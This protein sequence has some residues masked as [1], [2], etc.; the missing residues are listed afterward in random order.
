MI[1]RFDNGAKLDVEVVG[2]P[3]AIRQGLMWRKSLVSDGGMLFLFDARHPH[4]VWMKNTLITLDAAFLDTDGN[5]ALIV[6]GLVAGLVPLS[7]DIHQGPV[8][9][10]MLEV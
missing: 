8:S 6:A 1:L 5:G 9:V 2:S 3:D 4:A 10:A 7:L